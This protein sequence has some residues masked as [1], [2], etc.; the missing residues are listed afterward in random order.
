MGDAKETVSTQSLAPIAKFEESSKVESSGNKDTKETKHTDSEDIEEQDG[1][2]KEAAKPIMSVSNVIEEP[3][4]EE[5][6]AQLISDMNEAEIKGIK[7]IK[8]YLADDKE[9]KE[10]FMP[11]E[12]ATKISE[13]A[14]TEDEKEL[15]GREETAQSAA[16]VLEKPT[17]EIKQ[18]D[19]SDSKD[20]EDPQQLK[21]EAKVNEEP[22]KKEEYIKIDD[23]KDTSSV[24]DKEEPNSK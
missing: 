18:E 15:P 16:N 24:V 5:K 22:T 10:D 1:K 3:T 11:S 21:S 23:K 12:S 2:D 7:D 4:T 9:D 13:V 20:K 19:L 14:T 8:Q 6:E 17:T